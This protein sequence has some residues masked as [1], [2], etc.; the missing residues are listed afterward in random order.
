MAPNGPGIFGPSLYERPVIFLKEFWEMASSFWSGL[1][2]AIRVMWN[3]SHCRLHVVCH[4]MSY[5][6]LS[7]VQTVPTL[8]LHHFPYVVYTAFTKL[9][10]QWMSNGHDTVINRS[11]IECP[12]NVFCLYLTIE[13][14]HFIRTVIY[15]IDYAEFD[16]MYWAPWHTSHVLSHVLYIMWHLLACAMKATLSGTQS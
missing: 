16:R 6:F 5:N 4:I 14:M 9:L 8:T 10:E 11:A 2:D 3:C 15:H 12:T 7:N 13:S 1:L